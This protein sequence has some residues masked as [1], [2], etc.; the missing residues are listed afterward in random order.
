ME[1]IKDLFLNPSLEQSF[2]N[3]QS[4]KNYLKLHYS[5]K[6]VVATFAT[7]SFWGS[8][9]TWGFRCY[10]SKPWS[11]NSALLHAKKRKSYFRPQ[12]T[13][14]SGAKGQQIL[15]MPAWD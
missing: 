2:L 6:D 12:W 1:T 11:S 14:W 13:D 5:E 4:F 7:D 8:F 9:Y 15:H 3:I 10:T